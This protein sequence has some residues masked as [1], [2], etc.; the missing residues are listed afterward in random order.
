MLK[1]SP[2]LLILLSIL[3]PQ[4]LY[5][6]YTV[7]SINIEFYNSA[8]DSI[9]Q[10]RWDVDDKTY[11]LADITVNGVTYD[12]VGARYK[13]NSTF[14]LARETENPKFPFNIDIEHVHNDQD[15][16]GYEKLKLSN[17]LFDVTFVKETLGY[18]SAVSYTHLTLPTNREV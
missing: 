10:A 16:M 8:Y 9:L 7:H 14:F 3:Y 5:D 6:P 18:L 4:E 15:V 12:S 17:A 2:L 11:E 1:S 13:G